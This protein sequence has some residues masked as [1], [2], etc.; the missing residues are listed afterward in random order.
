MKS[1]LNDCDYLAAVRVAGR[2]RFFGATTAELTLDHYGYSG[3]ALPP[4]VRGGLSVVEPS[5]GRAFVEAMAD[6]E[7]PMAALADILA[8]EWSLAI[9]IDFDEALFVNALSDLP[10]ERRTPPSWEGSYGDPVE[11]LP[12]ELQ[13]IFDQLG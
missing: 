9:V 2:W 5:D 3:E 10:L 8:E 12:Q 7:V 4:D 6:N 11:R 1:R 13:A